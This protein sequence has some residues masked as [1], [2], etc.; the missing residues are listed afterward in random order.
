[1]LEFNNSISAYYANDK[2]SGYE[3]CKQIL[4][5][6]IM[7]LGNM[8]KTLEN[9]RF[10]KD[11]LLKTDKE[12]REKIFTCVDKLLDLLNE[13]KDEDE[14]WSLLHKDRDEANDKFTI[15]EFSIEEVSIDKVNM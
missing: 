4:L 9:M 5:R 14:I 2:E 12:E 11:F 7:D 15:D 10:Y 13:K 6:G 3:C 1:M 8:K